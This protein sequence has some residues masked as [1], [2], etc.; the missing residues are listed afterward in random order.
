VSPPGPDSGAAAIAIESG[1]ASVDH[2]VDPGGADP[3]ALAQSAI[4]ATLMP[5]EPFYVGTSRYP[6]RGI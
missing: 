3:S 1:A 2:I 5:G 6:P 4:V